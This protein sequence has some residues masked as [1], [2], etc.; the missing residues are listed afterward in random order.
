MTRNARLMSGLI[1]ITEPTIQYGGYFLLTSLMSK[2]SGYT[3]V[4]GKPAPSKFLQGGARPCRRDR[5][6]VSDLR[7]ACRR[8]YPSNALVV[9]RSDRSASCRDPYFG[10]FLFLGPATNCHATEYCG[11][12]DIH[13]STCSRHRGSFARYW[14]AKGSA[15]CL[16]P[17]LKDVPNDFTGVVTRV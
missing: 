1:L 11:C 16:S 5:H 17:G 6:F 10:G 14:F 13:R 9:V 3:R 8:G 4:H 12:P 7:D 2:D 15:D